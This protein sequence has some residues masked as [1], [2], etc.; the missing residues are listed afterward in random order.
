MKK[1]LIISPRPSHPYNAGNRAR[2][3][4]LASQLQAMGYDVY[5]LYARHDPNEDDSLMRNYWRDKYFVVTTPV[6]TMQRLQSK[7]RALHRRLPLP[8][9]LMSIVQNRALDSLY[10]DRISRRVRE[11]TAAI[12]FDVVIVVYVFMSKA[13]EAFDNRPL[14][15]IDTLDVFGNRHEL[16]AKHGTQGGWFSTSAAQEARGLSRADVVVAI[17]E[18]DRAYFEGL[19]ERTVIT[20]GHIAMVDDRIGSGVGNNTILFVGSSNSINVQGIRYFI[21]LILP[22]VHEEV[23]D[24]RLLVAG[25]VCEAVRPS[26]AVECLGFVEDLAPVYDRSDIVINPMP[27]GTGL[28]IKAIEAL[29]HA[30]PVVA[31]SAGFR[32]LHVYASSACLIADSASEFADAVIRLLSDSELR[33]EMGHAAI[34]GAKRWNEDNLSALKHILD[35]SRDFT[36]QDE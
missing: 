30:K 23:P 27:F 15:I 28:S 5:F 7:L 22:L 31:T 13:L 29:A 12:E 9:S 16:Y 24:A 34:A 8:G 36:G 33:I 4:G 14:K 3:V 10:D 2:I 21:D 11:L 35:L 19:V 6:S 1:I 32:G 17:T 18:D 26:R 25:P 20:V